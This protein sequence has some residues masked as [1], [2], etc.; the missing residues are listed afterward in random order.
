[1]RVPYLEFTPSLAEPVHIATSA[2][3]AGRTTAGPGLV[4]G[5]YATLRAD[6][7]AIRIGSDGYFG[8][9]ATVPISSPDSPS[10]RTSSLPRARARA[11][12]SST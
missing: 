9:R 2:V 11:R 8:R 6:G 12:S 7:E 1:M 3:V 4:L 10:C 5:E